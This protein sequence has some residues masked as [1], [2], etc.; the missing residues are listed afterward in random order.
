MQFL[1][2]QLA[3][4]EDCT[5]PGYHHFFRA[6]DGDETFCAGVGTPPA[7][8]GEVKQFENA[9]V[10]QEWV[11][12][13]TGMHAIEKFR[14]WLNSGSPASDLRVATEVKR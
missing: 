12:S 10:R 6:E 9:L 2:R 11:E 14:T 4:S 7:T 5:S 3:S 8:P 1:I 13:D